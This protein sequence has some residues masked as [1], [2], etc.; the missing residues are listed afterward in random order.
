VADRPEAERRRA[1]VLEVGRLAWD[2]GQAIRE[3]RTLHL[4][5]EPGVREGREAVARWA[6]LLGEVVP[7]PEHPE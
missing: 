2:L 1:L 3:A 6:V 5:V 7:P 4:P